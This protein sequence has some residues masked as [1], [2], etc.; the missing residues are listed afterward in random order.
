M[1]NRV[2]LRRVGCAHRFCLLSITLVGTA[3]PTFGDANRTHSIFVHGDL[4]TKKAR[5]VRCQAGFGLSHVSRQTDPTSPSD[6]LFEE[7]W[8]EKLT[9]MYS[10]LFLAT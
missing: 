2:A 10:Y 6:E 1:R 4:V 8:L 9:F 3:H 7:D 5:P